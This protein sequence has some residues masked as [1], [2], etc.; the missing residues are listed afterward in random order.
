MAKAPVKKQSTARKPAA[1]TPAK[2][3]SKKA[4]ARP[5]ATKV[6]RTTAKS[7]SPQSF[8]VAREDR[9]FFS[10]K[11]NVQTLY[12][13]ILSF[14]VLALGLWVLNV[15]LQVQNLYNELDAQSVMKAE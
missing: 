3:P 12:W 10:I 5:A 1:K 14:A 7:Q 8:R 9:P 2:K 11:P 6:R 15:N 4:P 13:A